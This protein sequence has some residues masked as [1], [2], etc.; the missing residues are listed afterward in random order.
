MRLLLDE[1]SQSRLVVRLLREAGHDAVTVSEAG[2]EAF[3]DADVL[4]RA[5]QDA[6]VVLTRNVRDFHALHLDDSNHEGI[7]VEYQDKDPTK[8]MSAASIV[9]AVSNLEESGWVIKGEFIALNAW[10]FETSADEP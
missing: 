8:N 6:R 10:G 9:R 4:K 5:R 3:L 7:L 2:M 1:D